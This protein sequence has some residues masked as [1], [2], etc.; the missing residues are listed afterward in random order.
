MTYDRKDVPYL[1]DEYVLGLLDAVEAE[2]IEDSMKRDPELQ[3]AIAASRDRFLPLDTGLSPQS[4]SEDVWQRIE[5][6]LPQQEKPAT[7]LPVA[8]DNG[9]RRWKF[10][11]LT[12]L[13]ASLILAVGLIYSLTRTVEPLVIA[14]LVNDAGEVQAVVEDFGNDEASVRLL[15]DFAVPRDKTI[16]VWTLPSQ[17]VGPVSLGLLEG[18]RSARLQGPALPRPRADQLYELTLEQAGGSPT[19]RPTGPILAKGFARMPR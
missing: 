10:A 15:A 9:V 19:G 18:V 12:S 8:N 6:A 7:P 16:Q 13:A 11:A 14:V 2:E 3:A 5:S 17:D 1:A 4:V